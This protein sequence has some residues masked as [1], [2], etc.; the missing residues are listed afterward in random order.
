MKKAFL[1]NTGLCCTGLA[2]FDLIRSYLEKNGRTLSDRIKDT[3]VIIVYACACTKQ[4]EELSVDIIKKA[5][6]EKNQRAKVI[7]TGCLPIANQLRLKRI[8][9]G[10]MLS[11]DYLAGLDKLLNA[12]FR[13]GNIKYV[14]LA[15]NN[16]HPKSEV[17]NLRIGWGCDGK[18]SYCVTRLVFGKP[19]SR[20]VSDIL[21]EFD[22]AYNKGYRKF[23]LAANDLGCYGEDL[24]ISLVQLMQKLFQKNK[25]SQ[26]MFSA[27]SVHKLKTMLPKLKTFLRT[28]RIW[29]VN[30]AIESGNDRILR[31]MGRLYKIND[32]KYCV[33]KLKEYAPN[34]KI[35]TNIMV[36]FPTETEEDF[37]DTMKFV[38]WLS[39]YV[40]HFS[41][42][43]Y[44]KRPNTPA[45]K[46]AGQL[47]PAVIKNRLQR[48]RNS[49]LFTQLSK[50]SL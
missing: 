10:S 21:R 22:V 17:Y 14:G 15:D 43:P 50:N 4:R 48:L 9:K 19:H 40:T 34:L 13:I 36:G 30:T 7:V 39:R 41:F 18:C 38:S 24:G 37:K 45:S 3:D 25:E 12:K 1:S 31:L 28:G 35:L 20:S 2:D 8:F 27:G 29:Q 16:G 49:H 46:M 33:R 26:F 6:K 42:I 44:S 11:A 5:L 23:I 47:A 32:C